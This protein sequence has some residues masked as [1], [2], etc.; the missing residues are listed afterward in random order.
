MKWLKDLHKR[1]F[2]E[3]DWVYYEQD[4][5]HF[6]RCRLTGRVEVHYEDDWTNTWLKTQ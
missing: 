5:E 3:R 6:R 4:E 2:P 1:M